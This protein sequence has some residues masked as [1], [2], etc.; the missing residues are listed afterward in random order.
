MTPHFSFLETCLCLFLLVLLHCPG[1]LETDFLLVDSI[2]QFCS[3][4]WSLW[5]LSS[6]GDDLTDHFCPCWPILLESGQKSHLLWNH[7]LTRSYKLHHGGWWQHP[8]AYKAEQE[9]LAKCHDL[10]FFSSQFGGLS[11]FWELSQD[12]EQCF[13]D[14]LALKREWNLFSL[15]SCFLSDL[16][17]FLT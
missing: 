4:F 2:T 8:P 3:C 12:N 16:A 5:A 6:V 14:L 13:G 1:K 10:P 7:T 11:K 9:A 17:P 15:D